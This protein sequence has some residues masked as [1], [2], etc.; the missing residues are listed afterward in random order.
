M[1]QWR[2][3]EVMSGPSTIWH[4]RKVQMIILICH[5]P[6]YSIGL[7]ERTASCFDL[8]INIT[9]F[10]QSSLSPVLMSGHAALSRSKVRSNSL[11]P[12]S[13]CTYG[14]NTKQISDFFS[15]WYL[16]GGWCLSFRCTKPW[17]GAPVSFFVW[18]FSIETFMFNASSS[19]SNSSTSWGTLHFTTQPRSCEVAPDLRQF[20]FQTFISNTSV[21]WQFIISISLQMFFKSSGSKRYSKICVS[22]YRY[23]KSSKIQ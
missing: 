14:A 7:V 20:L 12:S 10:W 11:R 6:W 8:W 2:V 5:V 19:K 13:T 9:Q 3:S 17:K 23:N 4:G 21:K 18:Q 15:F 22:A 1:Q 16:A